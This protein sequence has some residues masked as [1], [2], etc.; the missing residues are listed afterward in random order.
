MNKKISISLLAVVT[1]SVTILSYPLVSNTTAKKPDD[2]SRYDDLTTRKIQS[3]M[4]ADGTVDALMVASSDQIL[5]SE[6]VVSKPI[7]THSIRKSIMSIFIGMSQAEGM[8]SLDQTL[9]ELS[10]DDSVTPLTDV[11]KTATVEHLLMSRSGIYISSAGEHDDQITKRPNRG[12]HRPGEVYFSNNWDFNA[13]DS[14]LEKVGLPTQH[15]TYE[16]ARK[17]QFEDFNEDHFYYQT[18][19]HSEHKQYTMFMSARDLIKIGQLFLRDG[20]SHDGTELVSPEWIKK[21]TSSYTPIRHRVY[22]GYG[23]MWWV[24]K[25]TNTVWTDGWG[26]Q[27]MMIDKDKDLVIVSRNNTGRRLGELLWLSVL[28]NAS[29]GAHSNLLKVRDIVLN[30]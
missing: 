8:L 3:L 26:G 13:L 23:Y 14:V 25:D 16:L 6:G 9:Q 27:F 30:Q 17:L 10:I 22:T 5:F 29:N 15:R 28:G 19:K 11:E 12:E 24:D 4:A 2:L 7:N 20:R 21:S 1:I 18:T